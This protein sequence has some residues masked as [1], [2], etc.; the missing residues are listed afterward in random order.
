MKPFLHLAIRD[1]DAAAADEYAAI[2][3]AS[4]LLAEQLVH[5]RVDAGSLSPVDPAEYSGVF[6]GGSAF[7]T[8]DADK[9]ELQLRAE[10]E[11]GWFIDRAAEGTLPLLGLCYGI[12]VAVQH[13]G[14][15]MDTTHGE[16]TNAVEVQLTDEGREDPVFGD[17]AE[18]FKVCTGHKESC[19]E[20]PPDT[21][22]LLRGE[23]CPV[24]AIRIGEACYATQF[25]AELDA[26]QTVDRMRLYRHIGYFPEHEFEAVA[27]RVRAGGVEHWP[28]LIV[29]RFAEQFART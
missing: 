8:S 5:V 20:L 17:L 21:A 11:L 1:L 13:R 26:E 6:L 22:V 27:A 3:Q 18:R 12:G 29:R 2:I 24:Q 19:A 10:R 25:H 7:N 23:A 28:G 14:G 16:V 4:G 9:S 15:R